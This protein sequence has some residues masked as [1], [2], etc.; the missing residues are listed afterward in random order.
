M[1]DICRLCGDFKLLNVLKSIN[2][3]YCDVQ[4]KLKKYFHI[5][6]DH[7]EMLPNTVCF[8]CIEELNKCCRFADQIVSV[9]EKFTLDRQEQMNSISLEPFDCD[10]NKLEIE[11]LDP[12]L[13]EQYEPRIG[14]ETS[15]EQSPIKNPQN[16][17]DEKDIEMEIESVHEDSRWD[18]QSV[19]ETQ[20]N[21][22]FSDSS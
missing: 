2:D 16:T 21:S 12:V 14:K 5:S 10:S 4:V 3:K 19:D 22:K 8:R 9:Q 20:T 1:S 18:T 17:A 7:D 11:R 6:L 13:Y 15:E